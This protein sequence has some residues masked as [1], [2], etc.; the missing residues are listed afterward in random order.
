MNK[1][2][3][4]LQPVFSLEDGVDPTPYTVPLCTHPLHPNVNSGPSIYIDTTHIT[5]TVKLY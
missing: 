5:V 4:Y 3:S 2:R 1:L